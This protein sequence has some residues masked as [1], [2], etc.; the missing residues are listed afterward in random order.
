MAAQDNESI[1]REV[2]RAFND[3]D[4]DRLASCATSDARMNVVPF[5]AKLGFREDAENWARAFPDGKIELTQIIAQGDLVVAEFIGRGTNTGPLAGP[6]G[7]IRATGR[8]V[9]L[10]CVEV[11]RFRGGKIAECRTYF[12]GASLMAQLGLAPG[13]E[14][15][16]QGAAGRMT[17]K[18]FSSPDETRPFGSGRAEILKIGGG[19]VGRGIFEAGWKWSKH[20]KPIAGTETCQV[21]HSAYVLSGRM[22]IVMDSGQEGDV[23]PGDYAVIP[24]GHDAWTLGNEACVI[25]DFSGMERYA[26][27]ARAAEEARPPVH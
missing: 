7:E 13:A 6:A 1:V 3:K 20:V 25:V 21:A 24:P 12:D 22:H 17:I 14:A 4:L 27:G 9:E 23:E 16:A 15:Q 10:P 26:I 11:Y 2:H 5:Q 18:K 8:R 19:T